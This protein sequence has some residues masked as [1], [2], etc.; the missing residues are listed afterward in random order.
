[1]I[2]R[3]ENFLKE[4]KYSYATM[5]KII[6]VTYRTICRWRRGISKPRPK[7]LILI[8]EFINEIRVPVE[9]FRPKKR[10]VKNKKLSYRF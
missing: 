10:K 6:G 7:N 1:M 9:K 5:A 2:E 4:K 3:L 8:E